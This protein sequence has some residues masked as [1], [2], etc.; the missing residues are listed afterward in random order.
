L[1][2]LILILTALIS[3]AVLAQ[4]APAPAASSPLPIQATPVLQ[5]APS[6]SVRV[7]RLTR[8]RPAPSPAG[9]TEEQVRTWDALGNDPATRSMEAMLFDPALLYSKRITINRGGKS[10]VIEGSATR[11]EPL[12]QTD[13][14]VPGGI[15]WLGGVG[16]VD[17][18]E[19]IFTDD[20][21][22][23]GDIYLN[24]TPLGISGKG[25][26]AGQAG[27]VFLRGTTPL[28]PLGADTPRRFIP[29]ASQPSP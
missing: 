10:Y 8:F 22:I 4:Q 14:I 1:K 24:G 2:N 28:S 16:K 5:A 6:Q 11:F 15:T 29:A 19:I 3:G 26:V 9:L 25:A 12:I 20:G 7:E 23:T 18:A 21:Y 27:V 13:R 17:H